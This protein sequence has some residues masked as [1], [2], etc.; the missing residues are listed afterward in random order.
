MDLHHLRIFASV[1]KNRSFSKASKE[2]NLTQP[3]ISDHIK[4][5]EEELNCRL[6]DRLGRTNLPTP[7]AEHLYPYVIDLLEKADNL[8]EILLKSKNNIEGDIMI[9]ASTIPGTYILPD[10]ILSFKKL[11]PKINF[12]VTISDSAGVQEMVKNQEIYIGLV[13]SKMN[14]EKILYEPFTDDELVLVAAKDFPISETISHSEL[15]N[16]PFIVRETGSGTRRETEEI[17]KNLKIKPSD[18]NVVM[19]LGSTEAVKEAVKAGLGCAI[20]SY[21]AVN[22]YVR[23]NILKPIKIKGL[24]MRRKFYILS[25]KKRV[26]PNRYELLRQHILN[27]FQRQS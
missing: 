24:S 8:K 7:E 18:L 19:T 10:I 14:S 9:G 2:I 22:D 26:L 25:H 4:A 3:T 15:T 21:Y 5:L 13:G 11:Y 1:F 17:F 16:I 6:F 23:F 12:D 27:N 20:L